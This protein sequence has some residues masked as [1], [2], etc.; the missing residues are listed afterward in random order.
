MKFV[1]LTLAVLRQLKMKGFNV[2]TAADNLNDDD[3][4]WMPDQV[5][6]IWTF[7]I[8]IDEKKPFIVIDDAL[9][10]L[11]DEDLKGQ[12]FFPSHV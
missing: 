4:S 7:V 5:D 8:E 10:H 3:P 11:K 1:R 2:L 6:D 9:T 12:V